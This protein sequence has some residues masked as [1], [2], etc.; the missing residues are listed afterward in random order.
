MYEKLEFRSLNE[1]EEIFVVDKINNSN[2]TF[3]SFCYIEI[4][5]FFSFLNEIM[6]KFRKLYFFLT[7]TIVTSR[8]VKSF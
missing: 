6:D 5:Y 1:M 8:T 4:Y 2:K 7:G 3:I